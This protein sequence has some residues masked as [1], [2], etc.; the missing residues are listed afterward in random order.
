[1]EEAIMPWHHQLDFKFNQDFY[2]NVAGKRNT[3]Q[4]GVVFRIYLIYLI[5][6]GDYTKQLIQHNLLNYSTD[7]KYTFNKVTMKY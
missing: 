2:V 3:I 4:F 5:I 6:V 1:V 7:G